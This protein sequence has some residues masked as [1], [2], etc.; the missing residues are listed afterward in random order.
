MANPTTGYGFRPIG[1]I[2]GASPTFGQYRGAY[3]N[4]ANTNKIFYGDVMKPLSGGFM[5]VFTAPVGGGAA[6]GG[7]FGNN[8][9]WP[10]VSARMS[11]RRQYWPG[12]P[13]DVAAGGSVG[14]SIDVNSMTVF[15]VRSA[16]TS[17]GPVTAAQ[18]G[19]NANFVVGTGG[20]TTTGISS[21]MLDDANIGSGAS[22][23]FKIIGL[24]QAP[25]TDPTSV[26]NEVLVIFN[27]L[28]NP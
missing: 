16:G 5:D 8:V 4:P 9:N 23:P 2:D 15:Q 1:L 11:L 10:S 26:N 21:F 12:T 25:Q 13:S 6:V 24:V 14:V 28:T 7:I 3:V 18:V 19:L 27:N 20:N 22:L 17:G